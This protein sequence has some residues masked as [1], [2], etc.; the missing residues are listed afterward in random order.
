MTTKTLLSACAV[1][2][3]VGQAFAQPPV[4]TDPSFEE[5]DPTGNTNPLGWVQFNNSLTVITGQ[6]H[7]GSRSIKLTYGTANF[8]AIWTSWPDPNNP[9]NP[10]P[11]D[12]LILYRSGAITV[13]GWIMIPST[14]TLQ[15][16]SFASL[17]LEVRRTVNGSTYQAFE[18][19]IYGDTAGQW[20]YVEHTVQDSD[21]QPYPLEPT[22][23]QPTRC[24][25][26]CIMFGPN[27]ID[28]ISTVFYDDIGLTQA[29]SSTCYPN[30]D[31]STSP[32]ILNANDFQCFLNKYAAGDTYANCDGSTSPPIL[33]ANDFQC[34]L[35]KY[36]AGCS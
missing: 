29:S 8:A 30:C 4:V 7:T 28:P 16:S 24:T 32:P 12:P 18:W 34:F 26:D 36:A 14:G 10:F 27:G 1:L 11:Y 17:K 2:A 6:S 19:P 23:G 35:N 3:L 5:D 22:V 15:N 13:S 20:M 21:F 25:V 33:N 31:G 9:N